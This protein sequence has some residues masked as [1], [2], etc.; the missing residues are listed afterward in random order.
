MVCGNSTLS[1]KLFSKLK[2]ILGS[3]LVAQQIRDPAL[4]LQHL[5]SL[6]WHR[7]DPGTSTCHR[8]SQKKKKI[9]NYSKINTLFRYKKII[10][11]FKIFLSFNHEIAEPRFGL[12]LPELSPR[13]FS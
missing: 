1:L 4:S 10:A 3:S 2:T 13:N 5:G 11:T 9:K 7:F 6:L 8:F 12:L